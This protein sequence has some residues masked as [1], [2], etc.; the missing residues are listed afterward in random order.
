M[1]IMSSSVSITRYRVQGHLE[2]PVLETFSKAIERHAISDIDNQSTEKTCGWTSFE[3]PFTVEFD[4]NALLFGSCWVFSMRVE[5]KNIPSKTLKKHVT[6]E[7]SNRLATAGRQFVS[8]NEKKLIKEKV[9]HSLCMRIPATPHV[10]DLIWNYEDQSLWFFSNLK[11]ANEDF[12][13]LFTESFKLSLIR[14]FPYTAAA[15]TA[16]L[17]DADQ[18]RLNR[19]SASTFTG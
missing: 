19:I 9:L 10:Y 18:D 4:T 2:E 11:S 3:K 8:K 13:D 15:F 1:G 5:K 14:L 12:E 7:E 17:S 6:I 16:D